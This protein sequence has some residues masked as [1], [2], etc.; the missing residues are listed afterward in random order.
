LDVIHLTDSPNFLGNRDN[1]RTKAALPS[2]ALKATPM[3]S[4]PLVPP[5]AANN[6][7]TAPRLELRD[8]VRQFQVD[9][10]GKEVQDPSSYSYTWI[11]DQVGHVCMGIL[12]YFLA[13]LA[14]KGLG[15]D[16]AARHLHPLL[17]LLG[18]WRDFFTTLIPAWKSYWL[19]AAAVVV[20]ALAVSAYELFT[21]LLDALKAGGLFPLDRKLL[22]ANAAIAAFY[23]ILGV[24]VGFAM[25]FALRDHRA[26]TGAAIFLGAFVLFLVAAP[27]WFSQKITWQKAALPFVY[28]LANV[29]QIEGDAKV[30]QELVDDVKAPPD[31]DPRQVVIGGPIG[32][33]RTEMATGIGTEFAFKN[34]KVRYVTFSALLEFAKRPEL[35]SNPPTSPHDRNDAGP[36][37]IQYW[38]WI[39]AQVLIID[40][41]GPLI[42]AQPRKADKVAEFKRLLESDLECVAP[43]LRTCHTV[44]VVGTDNEQPSQGEM[45]P[46]TLRQL[47]E[48]ITAHCHGKKNKAIVIEIASRS[49]PTRKGPSRVQ[50]GSLYHV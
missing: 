41:I 12:A 47:A 18:W 43:I 16:W 21:F 42:S 3:S 32:S 37:N 7:P 28:R 22:A 31:K 49:P 44:W 14:M 46:P 1:L 6:R 35:I 34:K 29:N 40:D 10:V 4:A 25:Q 48:V 23:M 27:P 8:L 15:T 20:G 24:V 26:M 17:S 33:G 2:S 36:D 39:D 11:A 30:L 50:V 13:V 38:P 45:A 5:G 19:E 9:V